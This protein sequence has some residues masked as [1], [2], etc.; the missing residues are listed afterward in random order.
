M[1]LIDAIYINTSGGK[2]LLE[3]FIETLIKNQIEKKY[4]FLIDS[5]I[6]ISLVDKLDKSN[7]T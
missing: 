2:V 6:G 1:I 4:Y 7:Y 3:Y 5:R